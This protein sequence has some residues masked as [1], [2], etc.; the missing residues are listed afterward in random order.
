MDVNARFFIERMNNLKEIKIGTNI[1]SKKG[2]IENCD[3]LI[4]TIKR[5]LTKT[6]V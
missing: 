1:I 3:I 5:R 2:T 6:V 4:K